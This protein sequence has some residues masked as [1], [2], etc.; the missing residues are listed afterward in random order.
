MKQR[1]PD[2]VA[3]LVSSERT[4]VCG[5]RWEREAQTH[6]KRLGSCTHR[7]TLKPT[8]YLE[9]SATDADIKTCSPK[10]QS[11]CPPQ[12]SQSAR[13]KAQKKNRNF[14]LS[15]TPNSA[16]DAGSALPCACE[17]HRPRFGHVPLT[18]FPIWGLRWTG[19]VSLILG[20]EE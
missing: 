17:S 20:R 10:H 6:R 5:R 12:R 8:T 4:A 2:A 16:M 18:G 11:T 13:K 3:A 19:C 1:D 14:P 15:C 7:G 9:I